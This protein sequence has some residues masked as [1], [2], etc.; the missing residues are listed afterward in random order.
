[1]ITLIEPNNTYILPFAKLSQFL[2]IIYF[3]IW[4]TSDALLALFS[5]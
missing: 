5:V 4:F 3:V 2:F 1:M